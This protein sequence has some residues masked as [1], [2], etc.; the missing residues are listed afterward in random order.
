M[1]LPSLDETHD[2]ALR[3]WVTTANEPG[4]EF[5]IQ[6]LPFAAFSPGPGLPVRCGVGIGDRILDVGACE[7]PMR[8]EIERAAARACGAASLNDL[9][10]M[11]PQAAAALR[12]RLSQLLRAESG[13]REAVAAALVPL[14]QVELSL[15]VRIGGFTDFYASVHHATNVGRLMRPD[16]PL[17]P[18]YKYVPIA[19]NGRANSVRA[20]GKPVRRPCGQTKSVDSATPQFGPSLRLDYEVELGA[21]IGSPSGADEPVAVGDAWQHLFGFSLLN[22]WSARDIQAWEYQPLGPFLAK[23]FATTVSPWVVTAQ[24]LAPFRVGASA[25]APGD[26]APLPHLFARDDQQA[27]GIDVVLQAGLRTRQMAERGLAPQRLSRSTTAGLYWTFGQMV[28]HHTSNGCALDTGDLLGSGTVS[29]EG[30]GAQGALLELTAGGNRPL[31]V[32]STGEQRSFLEDGDEVILSGR[33]ERA[34][35]VSI[36]FGACRATVLPAIGVP[37]QG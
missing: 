4:A 9:M 25:R 33:C 18:N 8:G 23:S 11:G 6:N 35:F 2:P 26:P 32:P 17:L 31:L 28:A 30:E 27:G 24:A 3:S 16:N 15:P 7:G 29:N 14:A 36:G 12:R 34:G 1:T 20:S 19:Y 13:A 37:V 5:P 21:Y 10:R 22:D